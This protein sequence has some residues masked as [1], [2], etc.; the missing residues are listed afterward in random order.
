MRPFALSLHK[1]NLYTDIMRPLVQASLAQQITLAGLHVTVPGSL[2]IRLAMTMGNLRMQRML[3]S[4]L[5]PGATV[6]DVGAN[7]GYNTLYAAHKVGAT[8]RVYAVEPAQDNLALLYTNL[9]ANNLANVIVLPY[10]AGNKSARQNFYLRGEVSA[11]NSLYHDN[12]YAP[13]TETTEVLI[14]PLDDLIPNTPD[15]V[16]IDVE[17]GELNVL[18]GMTRILRSHSLR[19]IVEWHPTLQ[20]AA[21]YDSDELPR[22]LWDQGFS[23]QVVTHTKASFLYRSALNPLTTSLLHTRQPVELLATR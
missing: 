6:V 10:A 19:L 9:F 8:G 14:A 17:G 3:D 13:I 4:L 2:P 20:Q 11:V 7:I 21:G 12:F 22:F 5:H 18:Q 23:L 16:K 15:L 1:Y